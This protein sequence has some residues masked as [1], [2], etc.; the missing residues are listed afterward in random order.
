[1]FFGRGV[2]HNETSLVCGDFIRPVVLRYDFVVEI[3]SDRLPLFEQRVG[4]CES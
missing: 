2:C 1:M 3:P 4:A